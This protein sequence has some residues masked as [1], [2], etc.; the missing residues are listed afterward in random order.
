MRTIR[1]PSFGEDPAIWSTTWDLSA[2]GWSLGTSE[3]A[4]VGVAMPAYAA[5]ESDAYFSAPVGIA[6]ESSIE[7]DGYTAPVT[8]GIELQ[9]KDGSAAFACRARQ[10]ALSGATGSID[11]LRAGIVQGSASLP[12]A[13]PTQTTFK[14]QLALLDDNGK[15]GV[16]C[17]IVGPSFPGTLLG[18]DYGAAAL[19]LRPRLFGSNGNV[20]FHHVALYKL[21]T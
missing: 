1:A 15:L 8:V 17:S 18:M 6:L 16:R 13:L 5:L 19:E 14:L 20:R 2:S 12:Y 11:I 4:L 9:P 10:S 3:L 21:G 7:L